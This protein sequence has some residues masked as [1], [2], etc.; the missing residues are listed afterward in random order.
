MDFN[1][2]E[3][4][5]MIQDLVKRFALERVKPMAFKLDKEERFS[6]ELT[7]EMGE[8]GLFGMY[9]P[10]KYGGSGLTY[11]DYVVAIEEMAKI[12]SSQ[13]A[14]LAAH[15][16]LGI[17][18]IYYYGNEE[19][20]TE[21]LPKL[22]TGEHLWAFG[23][24]EPEAGSD[25]GGTK[26]SAYRS[27]DDKNKWILN[28]SKIFIT[29]GSTPITDGVT[30]QAA[31]EK[32]AGKRA[33]YT[34][35]LMKSGAKGFEART[36]HEKMMW[37][38]SNT[39]ELFFNDVIV[40]DKDILGKMGEG[41][42]IMLD[43]LDKGRLAIAAMGLG[44]AQGAYDLSLKYAK[45]RWQ[46]ARPISTFQAN[47]FKLADMIV[48]I[49]AARNLLYKAAWLCDKKDD[50]YRLYGAMA[51]LYCSEVAHKC[52]NAGVQIHGGYGLMKE[53]DIER[54]YRDQRLLEIGEGTSEIQRLVIAR[55]I[56]CYDNEWKI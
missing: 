26:T 35:F 51:K 20:K 43:T 36:M 38:A 19:Q 4:A 46:F 22:C 25:A 1:L 55:H 53:F 32:K 34:C 42:K 45:D 44:L 18:P 54:L 7:K 33:E 39:S 30:V 5:K 52:V 50:Q 10:E 41:F 3:D 29:N 47:S 11:L 21:Y 37:R 24:T 13:A 31:S 49:E 28:G 23:L 14:T 17:G 48:E 6:V 8:L 27:K 40:D 16:S 9:L 56:G 15:N 2:P 12:D